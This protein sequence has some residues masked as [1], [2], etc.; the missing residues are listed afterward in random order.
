[1]TVAF[2][3]VAA[4]H[5]LSA[6][7]LL[8]GTSGNLSVK[9]A[10]GLLITP[11]GVQWRKLTPGKLVW[12]RP[13]GSPLRPKGPVPSSEWPL[14]VELY[15]RRPEASAI[16]H[17]HSR[18]A[19]AL[20]CLRQ[21]VPAVHYMIAVSGADTV[22]CAEYATYGSVELAHNAARALEGAKACLLANH[23]LVALGAN[24]AEA[25]KVAVEIEQVCAVYWHARSVG[26][27][28]LLPNDEIARVGEKLRSYG[29]RR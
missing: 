5:E 11:S 26:E 29:Q 10:K 13:D 2:D 17:T 27:P 19:T 16:V 22:R 23:G 8:P 14:H 28:V 3:V 9:S 1:M 7:G 25:V 21:S 4:A 12:L 24:L 18:Y 15:R 6:A 20:S